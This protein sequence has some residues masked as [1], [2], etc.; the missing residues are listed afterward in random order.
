MDKR[1]T[2]E[3]MRAAEI[4]EK[5]RMAVGKRRDR[6]SIFVPTIVRQSHSQSHQEW[7]ANQ[8]AKEK[9]QLAE[10]EVIEKQRRVAPTRA[11]LE[12]KFGQRGDEPQK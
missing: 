5:R 1:V 9:R 3:R 8:A 10:R 7:A 4:S 11:E 12:R 6:I 2:A